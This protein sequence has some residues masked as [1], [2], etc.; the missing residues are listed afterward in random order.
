MKKI[1]SVMS[2]LKMDTNEILLKM[3]LLTLMLFIGFVSAS[4][5]SYSQATK[6]TLDM[7]D[8][9]IGDVFQKNRRAK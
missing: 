2:I 1:R 9:S 6:F 4:A 7:K 8:V 5:N 3:K